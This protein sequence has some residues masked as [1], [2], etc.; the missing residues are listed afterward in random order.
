MSRLAVILSA[1]L[2]AAACSN[3]EDPELI[4]DLRPLAVVAE[5]AEV[6]LDVDLEADD[7]LTAVDLSDLVDVEFCALVADPTEDRGLSYR[8]TACEPTRS[9][10]CDEPDNSSEISIEFGVGSIEDPELGA[11]EQMCGTLLATPV[12][13]MMLMKM[14]EQDPRRIIEGADVQIELRVETDGPNA[15]VAYA[16][17]SARYAGRLPVDRVANTNPT[18]DEFIITRADETEFV[19]P[20]G[21]CADIDPVVVGPG[22]TIGIEPI[23]AEGTAE[24][25]TQ[26]DLELNPVASEEALVYNWLSTAG[27]WRK[28]VTGG[29]KD[30]FG[31]IPLAR[32]EFTAPD[33][34]E[35][36][37]E[38][39][40][41]QREERYG[42]SWFRT[43]FRVE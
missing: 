1:G 25:Y 38:V 6:V 28:F 22:E 23:V 11:V 3:F 26:L 42:G 39:W 19:M 13:Q 32:N 17:K 5:P 15:E 34:A 2:L 8:F 30:P 41:T 7:L 9:F 14:V 36:D 40:I 4:I 35:G 27:D 21:R 24:E 18:I 12:L 16:R 20:L 33:E 31:N 10:R 29:P 43:C 37:I